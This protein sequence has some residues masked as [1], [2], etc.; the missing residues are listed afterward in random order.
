MYHQLTSQQRSLIDLSLAKQEIFAYLQ[1]KIARKN[2]CERVDISQSTL[3]RELK[4][5][6][7]RNTWLAPHENV[8][9]WWKRICGN[10]RTPG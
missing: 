6:S 3:C 10:R 9:V 4:F 5:N 1:D 7:G 2:I 8:M